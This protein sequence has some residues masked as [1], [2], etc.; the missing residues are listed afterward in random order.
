VCVLAIECGNVLYAGSCMSAAKCRHTKMQK[1]KG[2]HNEGVDVG[3]R[4]TGRQVG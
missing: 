3:E 1:Q 2:K 4:L